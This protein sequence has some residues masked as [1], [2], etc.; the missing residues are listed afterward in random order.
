MD[1]AKVI[2]RSIHVKPEKRYQSASEMRDALLHLSSSTQKSLSDPFKQTIAPV[3]PVAAPKNWMMY[4]GIA[5]V[6][7]IGGLGGWYFMGQK[8]AP[9]PLIQNNIPM[10]P[11]V[12][13]PETPANVSNPNENIAGN[14]GNNSGTPQVQ[15][16]QA[17]SPTVQVPVNQTAQVTKQPAQQQPQVVYVPTPSK[18]Q[19]IIQQVPQTRPTTTSTAT[20]NTQPTNIPQPE[21]RTAPAPEVVREGSLNVVVKDED[22]NPIPAAI[23]INGVIATGHGARVIGFKTKSGT[24][25]VRASA[26]GFRDKTISANVPAGGTSSAIV[27]LSKI[28]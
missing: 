11:P 28:Q 3:K 4:A 24:A 12:G 9:E 19:V 23:S 26:D 2:S 22:G 20:N 25:T 6:V 5:G 18:P 13:A 7:A 21:T 10:K 1:L 16:P 15:S 27:T 17:Q 14:T 8:P